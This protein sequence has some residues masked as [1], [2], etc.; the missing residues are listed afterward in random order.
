[1]KFNNKKTGKYRSKL[2]S[3]VARKLPRKRH[4]SVTYEDTRL[5]YSIEHEYFPDL[6]VVNKKTGKEFFI[7]V[8]GYFRQEDRR[9]MAAVRKQH[10]HLDIRM[11]FGS[12]GNGPKGRLAN[13]R[14]LRW[15][16]R[17]GLLAAIDTPPK[18]WFD[19]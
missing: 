18:E 7:E 14:N 3:K 17:H 10:P 4:L 19:E 13:E 5:V 9:K 12:S 1:M 2:E 11:V 8:K 16:E 6:R 15:C